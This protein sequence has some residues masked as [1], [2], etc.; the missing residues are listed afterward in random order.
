MESVL[1]GTW[2]P[3]C[4]SGASSLREEH[5]AFQALQDRPPL[6]EELWAS[7]CWATSYNFSSLEAC[8]RSG[9]LFRVAA[10]HLVPLSRLS[11]TASIMA[12]VSALVA[13]SQELVCPVEAA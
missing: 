8:A 13:R 10:Q 9:C 1:G 2:G 3:C 7:H 5:T 4:P 12:H 11:P 6:L